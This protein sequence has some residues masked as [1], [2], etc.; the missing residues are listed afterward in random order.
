MRRRGRLKENGP[1]I[2]VP[3]FL[4]L[5]E[6]SGYYWDVQNQSLCTAGYCMYN[7]ATT[8][9]KLKDIKLCTILMIATSIFEHSASFREKKTRHGRSSASPRSI[10]TPAPALASRW[11]TWKSAECSTLCGFSR[12]CLMFGEFIAWCERKARRAPYYVSPSP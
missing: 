5:Q 9:R 12:A 2:L 1:V 7:Y 4:C 3:P 6:A 8:G 11:V 10:Q